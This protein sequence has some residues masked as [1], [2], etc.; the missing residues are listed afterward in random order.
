MYSVTRDF[1]G[2]PAPPGYVAGLGRGAAG[3]TTR[4]DIGPARDAAKAKASDTGMG[5]DGSEYQRGVEI[6]LG[7]FSGMAYA[8]D[9]EEADGVWALIDQRMG[10]RRQGKRRR[11][12]DSASDAPAIE[13]QLRDAKRQ[14]QALTAADWDAIPDVAQVAETAARAKRR[15]ANAESH[16]RGERLTQVP[17][18]ALSGLK[19]MDSTVDQSGSTTDLRALGQARDAVLRMKLDQAGTATSIGQ[20]KQPNAAGLLTSPEAEIA[21]NVGDIERARRLLRSVTQA[22]P[23]HAAG[24]VA[25]ARLEEAARR[26][27]R[28]RAVIDEAC[29]RCPRS[30]DVWLEA[31]RLHQGKLGAA[32]RAVLAR[33]VR[34]LPQSVR[35]WQAAA[36]E[37]EEG[38]ARRRVLRRALEHVPGSVALWKAAVGA[39]PLPSDARVLLAAAVEAAPHSVDLWLALA[40]LVE[41]A[42]AAQAVLNRARRAVPT[43]AEIWLAA[44]RLSEASA[45]TDPEPLLRRALASLA[46]HGAEPSRADWLALACAAGSDGYAATCRAAVAAAAAAGLG[47]DADDAAE[48]RAAAW[49][50][51]AERVAE[52]CPGAARA[53]YAAALDAAPT[54]VATWHAAAAVERAHGPPGAAAALLSRAVQRQP[55]DAELWLALAAESRESHDAVRAVLERAHAALPRCEAVVLAAAELEARAGQPARALALLE[56]A[57]QGPPLDSAAN[58]PQRADQ[59]AGGSPR[60]WLRAAVLLRRLGRGAEA[61]DVA[62]RGRRRFPASAKLWLVEAQCLQAAGDTSAARQS[63][64]R[65]CAACPDSAPLW[66]AAAALE[67]AAGAL[68]RAR[69]LLERARVHAP[70]SPVLWLAAI[71]L[72][73]TAGGGVLAARA[74]LAR[75]V[76]ECPRSGALRAE[77]VVLADRAGRKAASADALRHAGA[78]DPDVCAVVARLFAAERR[79]EKARAWFVRATAA[80]PDCGDAWAWWLRFELSC[81][82]QENNN[83]SSS[84]AEVTAGA[85]RVKAL[86]DACA[87]AAPR[88]GQIWPSIAKDPRNAEL[89]PAAM[90]RLVADT[91]NAQQH[92]L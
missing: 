59:A 41:P 10:E 67:S 26:P 53:L 58:S 83:S 37:E 82:D 61:R 86:E 44:A 7:H 69:A 2:K 75:A 90:L 72:E 30:E 21:G 66:L 36:A 64:A 76:R 29:E 81:L 33:A 89:S 47:F 3:F 91:L 5:D 71:R 13:E 31:A 60:V 79:H 68:P 8:E 22:S 40:R 50:A 28:A 52:D 14:L 87:K 73:S 9:D 18:S 43:S 38:D 48:D 1:I 39:E 63:L 45:Q 20:Q 42:A 56:R 57:Q 19:S 27:A 55:H 65:A 74:L 92:Q 54:H 11:S 51:D 84:E 34:V 35:L 62:E 23:T 16:R 6:E 77:A 24:W 17:D 70:R 15:R 46:A 88:H 12:G 25:A 49:A 85:A 32:A 78:E 80:D 4:S